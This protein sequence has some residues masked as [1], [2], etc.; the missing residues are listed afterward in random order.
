MFIAEA[1]K[2]QVVHSP[3]SRYK[4]LRWIKGAVS[5]LRRSH[6]GDTILCW[7]DFQSVLLWFMSRLS[8]RR[9]NIVAINLM[10]KDKPTL[11][12]RIVSWMYGRALSAGD[13]KA[14]VTSRYYGKWLNKK[15]GLDID[16][17]LVRDVF[18]EDYVVSGASC[19]PNTVFC[20]GRNGRDWNFIIE[21]A[22]SL[23]GVG[24]NLVM[25]N[26]EAKSQWNIP[27][28]V[29]I[30]TDI[31]YQ[32][33]MEVMCRCQIV[34]LPL[35]TDAPAGLIVMFQAAANKK[36]IITTRTATTQ[37]YVVDERGFA[38]ENDLGEWTKTIE[39]ALADEAQYRQ[40]TDNMLKYLRAE[41]SREKYIESLKELLLTVEQ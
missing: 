36:L 22:R 4:L 25:S 28:N 11:T 20:G 32:E 31:P 27:A 6:R 30:Y 18:S 3:Q 21:I 33:F 41:C 14:S 34:C 16:Y 24:F 37:E 9:R 29:S 5:A 13:F 40:K 10:L 12:N 26:E 7:Y 17:T 19:E 23:P 39:N 35:D 38:I 8:H 15:L 2:M 1:M